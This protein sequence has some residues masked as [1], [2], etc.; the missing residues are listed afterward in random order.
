MTRPRDEAGRVAGPRRGESGQ[1]AGLEMVFFGLLVLVV[2]VLVIANAW[3]VVQARIAAG[4]AATQAARAFVQAEDG[5]LAPAAAESAARDAVAA[6]GRDPRRITVQVDG[7]LARCAR[8]TVEVANPVSLVG[9][10]WLG[11]P[12]RVITVHARQ[13]ELVDPY[14][15]GLSGTA[16][17]ATG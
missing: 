8:V 11:A 5:A 6:E 2:G 15:S 16:T 12:G 14:R 3:A 17:C 7:T 4:D 13:S 9:L 10:P 1:V